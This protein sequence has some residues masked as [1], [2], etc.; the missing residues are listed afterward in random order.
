MKKLRKLLFSPKGTLAVFGAAVA[1]L[2]LSSVGGARAALTYYSENHMTEIQTQT[3]GVTLVEKTGDAK[4]KDVENDGG[5]LTDLV[6]DGEALKV[7][8]PYQETLGVRNSGQIDQYVRVTIYKYWTNKIGEKKQTLYPG[9]IELGLGD[10]WKE[11][12]SASTQE[13][14]VLY[15]TKPLAPGET[16]DF[17]TSLKISPETATIVTKNDIGG[18]DYDYQDKFFEIK[19]D[20]DAVQTHNAEDAI[21][22]AWGKQVTV[23][24]AGN[25]S[26]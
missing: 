9:Y 1:L 23:D 11:D 25:L 8:Y 24:G 4:A 14:T 22:S 13:R 3:I 10:D 20:V 15:Y 26:F 5:L 6:P 17:V 12:E 16:A 19:V 18:V 21:L 7:G 2:M